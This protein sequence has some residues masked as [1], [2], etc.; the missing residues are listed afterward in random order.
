M[1][2]NQPYF[3]SLFY[4]PTFLPNL[5]L[6]RPLSL[7]ERL[8]GPKCNW[9]WL[10]ADT[11]PYHYLDPTNPSPYRS[12]LRVTMTC[13]TTNSV[14]K[15][16]HIVHCNMWDGRQLWTREWQTF[17]LHLVHMHSPHEDF[18]WGHHTAS[19]RHDLDRNEPPYSVVG[20]PDGNP[21][22]SVRGPREMAAQLHV[23]NVVSDSN[24]KIM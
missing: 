2:S 11:K 5:R 9:W 17:I 14:S 10:Y 3:F 6:M 8:G 20:A 1:R 13:N 7:E 4:L 16:Y 18:R 12:C 24:I 23:V 21:L 22:S 15:L 19:S